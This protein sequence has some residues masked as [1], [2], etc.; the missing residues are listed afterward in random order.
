MDY[1]LAWPVPSFNYKKFTIC[2]YLVLFLA[3]NSLGFETNDNSKITANL[4]VTGSLTAGSFEVNS[5]SKITANLEVTGA[6]KAGS[7]D[8]SS[9]GIVTTI[10]DSS[11]ITIPTTGAVK[12]YVDAQVAGS[13]GGYPSES[14][15]LYDKPFTAKICMEANANLNC[16]G[17]DWRLPTLGELL[18]LDFRFPRYVWTTDVGFEKDHYIAV[19]SDSGSVDSFDRTSLGSGDGYNLNHICVR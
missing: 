1:Y 13:S 2:I 12:A 19:N 9:S 15:L 17:N 10:A 6:F 3:P 11:Q 5:D 16:P 18:N 8:S 4:E 14:C 7:V